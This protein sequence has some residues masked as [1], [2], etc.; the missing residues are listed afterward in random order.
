MSDEGTSA[1][2]GILLRALG[3]GVVG[4]IALPVITALGALA[5]GH[6]AGACGAGSSGGCE[7]GAALFGLYAILPGLV[8]GAGCSVVRDLRRIRA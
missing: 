8:L 5:V 2:P 1:V 3:F 7:M 6:L 4:S